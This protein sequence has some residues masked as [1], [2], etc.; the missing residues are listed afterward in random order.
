[1]DLFQ[2]NHYCHNIFH[3]FENY[4]INLDKIFH[5]HDLIIIFLIKY[6]ALLL[7]NGLKEFGIQIV[8]FQQKNI[9]FQKFQSFTESAKHIN[10][11]IEIKVLH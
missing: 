3:P 11:M 9:P 2:S 4:W 1:M 10:W 5:H 7:Q 8:L 6:L